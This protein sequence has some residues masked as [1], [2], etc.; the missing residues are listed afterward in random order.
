VQKSDTRVALVELSLRK[1]QIWS[2]TKRDK[3]GQHAPEL[4]FRESPHKR[5]EFVIPLGGKYGCILLAATLF[6]LVCKKIIL[7]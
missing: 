2:E 5:P 3:Y 6:Y 1:I 7:K 4:P